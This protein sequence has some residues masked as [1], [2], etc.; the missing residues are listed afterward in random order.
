MD[1]PRRRLDEADRRVLPRTTY[2]RSGGRPGSADSPFEQTGP[3][4]VRSRFW[5]HLLDLVFICL[6][7]LTLVR[8]VVLDNHSK[9]IAS[10]LSY[11][12]QTNYQ[13]S[14]NQ[15]LQS[16]SNRNKITFNEQGIVS[17]LKRDYPEINTV[18]VE[19]PVFGTKPVIRLD[20]APP[21]FYL[22]AGQ[23]SYIIDANGRVIAQKQ[24]YA[25]IKNLTTIDDQ[26]GYQVK[27][28]GLVLGRPSVDFIK[29]LTAIS[30]KH[31]I[32]IKSLIL[33]VAPAELDL[34][35][36]DQPYF[37]KFYLGGDP[38][39]QIGQWLAAR[40]EFAR[41]NSQPTSYLDVRVAGKVF[42]K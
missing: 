6:L 13:D 19:L 32:K 9:V 23:T 36:S 4:K 11:H 29:Q 20:I 26:S 15:Y 17:S 12:S 27:P 5:V 30:A 7:L 40:A 28:G 3:V 31:N 34:R 33:P 1:R 16:L 41:K 42:Y 37:V 38:A 14:A 22:R 24:Q 18:T 25:N 35:T 39:T 2:Y 21:S 10:N 8:A